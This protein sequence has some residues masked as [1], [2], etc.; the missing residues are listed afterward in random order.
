MQ[1]S[2]SYPYLQVVR[3][4]SSQRLEIFICNQLCLRSICSYNLNSI[5]L[6]QFQTLKTTLKCLSLQG[7]SKVMETFVSIC[8]RNVHLK[9]AIQVS[10]VHS[11]LKKI[12]KLIL[13]NTFLKK[14]EQSCKQIFS[15]DFCLKI[16][17]IFL[18][19]HA[20]T[21]SKSYRWMVQVYSHLFKASFCLQI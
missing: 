18:S 15:S 2:S 16:P 13:P 10:L 11:V 4:E 20:A 8:E 19:D 5:Y 1:N 14:T 3:S 12:P 17:N 9:H 21:K 7:I 6:Q